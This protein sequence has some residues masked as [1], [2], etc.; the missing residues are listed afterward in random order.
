VEDVAVLHGALEPGVCAPLRR[1][2]DPPLGRRLAR[3]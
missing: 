1:D 3:P 2:S